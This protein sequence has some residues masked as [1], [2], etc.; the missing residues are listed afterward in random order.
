MILGEKPHPCELCG[1]R[2]RVRSDMKRHYQTHNRK[3]VNRAVS[4]DAV[5]T[6]IEHFENE[7]VESI[8]P[9][10]EIEGKFKV[11]GG[12]ASPPTIQYKTEGLE[13][14]REGNTLYVMP[15]LIS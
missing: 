6:K 5:V 9:D 4:S 14:V 3:R 2:F 8:L 13:N 15:I 10:E 7:G 1:K 11:D 12:A